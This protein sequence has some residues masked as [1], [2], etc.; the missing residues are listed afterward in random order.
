MRKSGVLGSVV[1]Q[2]T[3]RQLADPAQPLYLRRVHQGDQELPFLGVRREGD[4][5]VDRIAIEA[6]L[7]LRHGEVMVNRAWSGRNL[8]AQQPRDPQPRMA[9]MTVA[10]TSGALSLRR[11]ACSGCTKSRIFF[12]TAEKSS[13]IPDTIRD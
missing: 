12:T 11:F 9:S 7:S 1:D 5:I 13:P 6:W 2:M 10:S 4:R 8:K 3:E